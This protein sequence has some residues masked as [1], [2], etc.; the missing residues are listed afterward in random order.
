MNLSR[1]FFLLS[2]LVFTSFN[3]FSAIRKTKAY[4][5]K[6]QLSLNGKI[7]SSP[8]ITAK[9]GEAALITQKINDTDEMSFIEVTAIDGTILGNTGIMMTFKVGTIDANGEKTIYSKPH[10]FAKENKEAEIVVEHGT[11]DSK[12]LMSLT[13]LAK[14]KN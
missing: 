6:M 12:E 4:D 11:G 10:V 13:I 3:A 14:S 5:L 8:Q 2:V 9:V 7:I 1:A